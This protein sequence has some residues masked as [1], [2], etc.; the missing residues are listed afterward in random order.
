VIP[1][2]IAPWRSLTKQACC[3]SRFPVECLLS[4]SSDAVSSNPHCSPR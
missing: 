4:T 2:I 1:F 3:V